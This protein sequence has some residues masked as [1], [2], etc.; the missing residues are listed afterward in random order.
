MAAAVFQFQG[1]KLTTKPRQRSEAEPGSRAKP[2]PEPASARRISVVRN[3]WLVQIAHMSDFNFGFARTRAA[4][5]A[6]ASLDEASPKPEAEPELS[7]LS[8]PTSSGDRASLS[9]NLTRLSARQQVREAASDPTSWL[10][11]SSAGSLDER[12]HRDDG[13]GTHTPGGFPSRRRLRLTLK[14][15]QAKQHRSTAEATSD[16]HFQAWRAALE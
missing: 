9:E 14:T 10:A 15:P 7:G 4:M 6:R 8:E 16:P 12:S 1:S 5:S 3:F 2:K 11:T 13:R